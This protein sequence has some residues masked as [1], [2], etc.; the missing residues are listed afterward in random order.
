VN[1]LDVL[2]LIVVAGVLSAAI[3]TI[4]VMGLCPRG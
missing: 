4:V 1:P 3:W 2:H